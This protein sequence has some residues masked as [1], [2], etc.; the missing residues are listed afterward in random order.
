MKVAQAVAETKPS[1]VYVYVDMDHNEVAVFTTLQKAKR[2]A[3]KHW[4]DC[5]EH[6]IPWECGTRDR[7]FLGEY[8]QVYACTVDPI[9]K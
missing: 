5:K 8:A 1:K 7:W 2:Y 3:E 6:G 4:P 9:A